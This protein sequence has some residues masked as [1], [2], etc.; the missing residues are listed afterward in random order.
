MQ[1]VAAHAP[2]HQAGPL[3]STTRQR[4]RRAVAATPAAATVVVAQLRVQQRVKLVDCELV[5]DEVVLR[6]RGGMHWGKG[7]WRGCVR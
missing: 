2:L 4:P 1:R 5:G 6:S 3:S 7:W